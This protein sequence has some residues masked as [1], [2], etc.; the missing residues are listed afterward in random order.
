MYINV[1]G[2]IYLI[3]I[4]ISDKVVCAIGHHKE[5]NA[6]IFW[7]VLIVFPHTSEVAACCYTALIKVSC[8]T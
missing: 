1:Y 5:V 7:I 3:N 2:M 6:E 4:N 8:G